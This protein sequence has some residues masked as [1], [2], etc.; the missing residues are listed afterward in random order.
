MKTGLFSLLAGTALMAAV[1]AQAGE[2]ITLDSSQ[3]D[4]VSAGAAASASQS[5]AAV[6]AAA[7]SSG[8]NHAGVSGATEKT[9]GTQ[10]LS[11][12]TVNVVSQ[13]AGP[14]SAAYAGQ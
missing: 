8:A 1:A 10:T 13:P 2:P 6:G 3:M 12:G 14:A 11:N 7:A 5:S 4:K 9:S